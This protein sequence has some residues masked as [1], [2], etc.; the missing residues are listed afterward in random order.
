[1]KYRTAPNLWTMTEAEIKTLQRGQWVYCC[2]A[3]AE[4][5]SKRSRYFGTTSTGSHWVAH[6]QGCADR[7]SD[8]KAWIGMVSSPA[9]EY[10]CKA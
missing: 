8:F 4:A 6:W 9:T 10:A 2:L 1:M 7:W 5:T 3:G